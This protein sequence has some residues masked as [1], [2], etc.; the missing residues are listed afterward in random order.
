ME[1]PWDSKIKKILGA[2]DIINRF[3][4]QGVWF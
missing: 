3:K 4:K 2:S 1:V